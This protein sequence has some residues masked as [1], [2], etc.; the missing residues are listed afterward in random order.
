MPFS[1]PPFTSRNSEDSYSWPHRVIENIRL[2]LSMPHAGFQPSNTASAFTS[3]VETSTRYVSAQS[4]SAFAHVAVLGG[5]LFLL[6]ST[7]GKVPGLRPTLL[8]GLDR[9]LP[10]FRPPEPKSG[11]PSLGRRG[12]GSEHDSAPARVGNL[13]PASSRPLAPPRLTHSEHEDLPVPPAVFDPKAP[14]TV[15]T[16]TKSRPAMDGQRHGF[17]GEGERPR[18]RKPSR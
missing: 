13:V 18:N 2:A 16:I 8:P 17:G 4:I 11:N 9:P 5:L 12:G 14:A 7:T 6:A 1:V 10:F 15:P 3:R